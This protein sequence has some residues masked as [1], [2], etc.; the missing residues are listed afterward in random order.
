MV[1]SLRVSAIADSLNCRV[2]VT[3]E[4]L[5]TLECLDD[6]RMTRRLTRAPH[7]A[8]VHVVP[9]KD[10]NYQVQCQ[11]TQCVSKLRPRCAV[12]LSYFCARA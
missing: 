8:R 11:V 7:D 10:L 12:M 6:E 2:Y 5:T 3:Q 1:T 9:M 4:K